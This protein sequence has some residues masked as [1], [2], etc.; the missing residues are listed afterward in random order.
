ML[1][2]MVVVPA[3]S[4]SR[5]FPIFLDKC[6]DFPLEFFSLRARHLPQLLPRQREDLRRTAHGNVLIYADRVRIHVAHDTSEN[7]HAGAHGDHAI[8]FEDV[9][10]I[11]TCV[12]MITVLLTAGLLVVGGRHDDCFCYSFFA[13]M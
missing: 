12:D 7:F 11:T 6:S 9:A 2:F 4:A 3:Q 1:T 8:A 5:R 13:I 10:R